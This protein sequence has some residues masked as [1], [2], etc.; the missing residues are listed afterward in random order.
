MTFWNGHGLCRF[1][2]CFWSHHNILKSGDISRILWWW[3]HFNSL[4]LHLFYI[5][6]LLNTIQRPVWVCHIHVCEDTFVVT[7]WILWWWFHFPCMT[8]SWFYT[9][10][11]RNI[12]LWKD[13]FDITFLVRRLPHPPSPTTT[14]KPLY[15]HICTRKWP[16]VVYF[17]TPLTFHNVTPY[18]SGDFTAPVWQV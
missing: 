3:L 15:L 7:W 8:G 13:F 11:W 16:D 6:P 18:S 9:L 2:P 12:S 5:D 4:L 10:S 1:G 17:C 14:S